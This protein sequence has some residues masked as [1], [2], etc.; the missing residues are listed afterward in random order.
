MTT[1]ILVSAICGGLAGYATTYARI[2]YEIARN[3]R[4][5]GRPSR[6]D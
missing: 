6:S 1:T 2:R 5:H 3:R 4:Q